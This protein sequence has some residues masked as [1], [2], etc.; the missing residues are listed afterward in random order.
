MKNSFKIFI[1]FTLCPSQLVRTP[2][3]NMVKAK[4]NTSLFCT[5][6]NLITVKSKPLCC[7]VID[8]GWQFDV[9]VQVSTGTKRQETT[10]KCFLRCLMWQRAF[11]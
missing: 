11:F 8:F 2:T 1:N 7:S 6:V 4:Q 9:P 5:Y 3:L 10:T